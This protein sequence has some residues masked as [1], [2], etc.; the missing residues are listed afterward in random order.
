MKRKRKKIYYKNLETGTH[1]GVEGD[2]CHE[3]NEE[4]SPCDEKYVEKT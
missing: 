2:T 1:F 3:L 4:Q